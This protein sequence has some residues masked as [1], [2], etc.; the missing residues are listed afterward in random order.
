M[1]HVDRPSLS[2]FPVLQSLLAANFLKVAEFLAQPAS[3]RAQ[4]RAPIKSQ[5]TG[6]I[7]AALYQ[8]FDGK[9]AYC[10]SVISSG[11]MTFDRFWPSSTYPERAFDWNNLYLCCSE[12]NLYKS[13]H[14]PLVNYGLAGDASERAPT[15]LL[16][17]PCSTQPEQS[18]EFGADGNVCGLNAFGNATIKTFALNR[19]SLIASRSARAKEAKLACSKIWHSN[20][21][22]NWS[23]SIF[24]D[25]VIETIDHSGRRRPSH[26]AV[27]IA[28]VRQFLI[29]RAIPVKIP[30]P[31][32]NIVGDFDRLPEVQPPARWLRAVEIENFKAI[33]AL[34]LDFATP[35]HNRQP[36]LMLL[37]ENG[38]GKTTI[39]EAIALAMIGGDNRKDPADR[40]LRQ[41]ALRGH[42][43]LI[44]N[45]GSPD[46]MLGFRRGQSQF[47]TQGPIPDMPI[48]AYGAT[49]LLP[50][51][52]EQPS[53]I[54]R[55]RN[56]ANLFDPLQALAPVQAYLCNRKAV[57]STAFDHLAYSLIQLLDLDD[58]RDKIIRGRHALRARIGTRETSFAELSGGRKSVLGL[59]M[60]IMFNLAGGD[61]E[62][63]H[64][65]GLVLLD[66]IELH[67]HP[68]WKVKIVKLL[69]DIF[70]TVRFITTTHDP[71]C[72]NGL[73]EGELQVL[74]ELPSG[75]ER[76][77]EQINIPRG[78]RTDD[79]LTGPWFGLPS[80][81]DDD[82]WRKMN[83]HSNLLQ[84]Q[85]R[86]KEEDTTMS[87]LEQELRARLGVFGDTH[88]QRAVLAVAAMMRD[89]LPQSRADQI[90]R[91][92]LRTVLDEQNS[93]NGDA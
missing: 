27:V 38:V 50:L 33:K 68:R 30:E 77:A 13:G 55:P 48:L 73:E 2:R 8:I 74:Y 91:A 36:W 20:T 87:Q 85:E 31:R 1:I 71:L 84:Q 6:E 64:L 51:E 43:R 59:A 28:V 78:T 18:L 53:A 57:N 76:K 42:V 32:P 56:I 65:E 12:C 3:A 63:R 15:P 86:S 7:H 81:M 44:W 88:T 17:D 69:R 22:L 14:F 62:M 41:G 29:E 66:E 79:I 4:R 45:D 23:D 80:T 46:F 49:R 82:T 9:C 92:R 35:Q 19:P 89:V 58:Q 26:F 25:R 75:H 61:G 70:P 93:E 21:L 11:E 83:E 40:W 34:R 54:R 67:L 5:H 52:V 47:S 10:E 24:I 60:D 39:L 90:S 16:L 37:G 72:A